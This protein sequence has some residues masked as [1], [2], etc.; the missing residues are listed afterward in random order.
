MYRR[1]ALGTLLVVGLAIWCPN[2]MAASSPAVE[3]KSLRHVVLFKFKD[4]ST[5]RDIKQIVA[6]FRA[7]PGKIDTI[8]DFEWG[9]DVSVENKSQG[10]THCFFVTFDDAKGRDVY[11]PHPAHKEFVNLAVPHIDK[12]LVFDYAAGK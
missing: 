7:L 12:V 5:P 3:A 10:F 8:K 2:F 6:A 1:V 4:S 9:T 11:L